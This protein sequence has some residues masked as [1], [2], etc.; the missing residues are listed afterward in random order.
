VRLEVVD[1]N[2]SEHEIALA[3]LYPKCVL[4]VSNCD[5][6]VVSRNIAV[7]IG[8]AYCVSNKN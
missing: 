5:D 2:F 6:E 4:P 3:A 1:H 7:E 8:V